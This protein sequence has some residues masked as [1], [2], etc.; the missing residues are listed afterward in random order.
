MYQDKF[1]ELLQ[2]GKVPVELVGKIEPAGE[3]NSVEALEVY[4]DD[5]Y[6]RLRDYLERKYSNIHNAVGDALFTEMVDTYILENPSNCTD[7]GQY[8]LDFNKFVILYSLRGVSKYL[9]PVYNIFVW[10]GNLTL[11]F[12][13]S[14][15]I[16]IIA[17]K[18]LRGETFK[19]FIHFFKTIF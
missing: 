17:D 10:I 12:L 19:P 14:F 9:E 1:M 11:K 13:W 7:L 6:I 2:T 18:F 8:G 5:Y 4:K 15:I 16:A 3:L